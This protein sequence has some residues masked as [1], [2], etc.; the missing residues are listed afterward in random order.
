MKK[1]MNQNIS[2]TN[3]VDTRKWVD[4]TLNWPLFTK[5]LR[6]N[7]FNIY[8]EGQL[9]N[10]CYILAKIVDAISHK[11]MFYLQE[12]HLFWKVSRL[13]VTMYKKIIENLADRP[14]PIIKKSV[15]KINI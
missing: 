6:I 11:I 5:Q 13:K 14:V 15:V 3:V 10:I 7:L 2:A 8:M 12:S 9:K 1:A 4:R